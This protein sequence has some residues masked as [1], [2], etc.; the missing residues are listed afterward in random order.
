[1]YTGSL[2]GFKHSKNT[3]LKLK[4][5][6]KEDFTA[7]VINILNNH[8]YKEYNYI[9]KVA[10]ALNIPK[11]ALRRYSNTSKILRSISYKYHKS[12]IEKNVSFNKLKQRW[13]I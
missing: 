10:K 3:I 6:E 7:I 9:C 13:K 4:S 11:I 2:L 8:N 12:K 5:C 1:M